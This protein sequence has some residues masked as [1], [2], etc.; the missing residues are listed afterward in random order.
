MDP[1]ETIGVPE[2]LNRSRVGVQRLRRHWILPFAMLRLRSMGRIFTIRSLSIIAAAGIVFGLYAKS[3][4]QRL[5]ND[6]H[7]NFSGFIQLGRDRFDDNPLVMDR[8]EIRRTL[9]L[10]DN[11]GYDGQFM[12]YITF[13]PFLRRLDSYRRVVDYPPYRYGR[14]GFP[15]MI[16][17]FSADRW[18]L[19][20]VVMIALLLASTAVASVGLGG[21]ARSA[22]PVVGLTVAVVPGFWE[23]IPADL[24]EPLAAA[25]VITAFWCLSRRFVALAGASFAMSLLVRETG[26]LFL[27]AAVLAELFGRR[28]RDAVKLGA[29]AVAPFLCWRLYV[30]WSQYP[31]YGTE[32]FFVNPHDFGLPFGGIWDMWRALRAHDYYSGNPQVI[33]AAVAYPVLLLLGIIVSAALLA[34]VPS[35]AAGAGLAFGIL[36]ISLNYDGIWGGI[37][38]AI[39]DTFEMFVALA[40]ATAAWQRY[41]LWVRA[42][43]LAFWASTAVSVFYLASTADSARRATEFWK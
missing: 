40:I 41:R 38:G 30:A 6:Y 42:A 27:V 7:G 3:V 39:R 14:I 33:R 19:Y 18:R 36:A 2:L 37:G 20:P 1:T 26:A 25:F 22:L 21:L 10:L 9:L 28:P 32:A 35:A 31:M 4:H 16:K 43:L 34:E 8:P 5:V 17:L 12:Y 11:A 24:P 23:S 29:I 13:D 15:L